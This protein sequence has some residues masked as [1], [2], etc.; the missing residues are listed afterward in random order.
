MQGTDHLQPLTTGA[1]QAY[2]LFGMFASQRLRA[3]LATT[4]AVGLESAAIVGLTALGAQRGFALPLGHLDEWLRVTPPADALAAAL[5]WVALAGAWWLLGGTLL[6]VAAVAA[7]A[8]AAGRAG[9]GT[10][11]PR[12]RRVVDAAFAVT[13]VAGAVLTPATAAHAAAPPATTAAV[14]DGHGARI[15]ALPPARGP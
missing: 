15:A 10:A 12:V 6:Y 3:V 9:R 1:Y 11:L 7:R 4:L 14:R 2:R 5:R 13:V 8:P